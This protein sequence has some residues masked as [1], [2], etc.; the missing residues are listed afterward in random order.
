MSM[1]NSGGTQ[2]VV[3]TGMGAIS[4]AGIGVDSLWDAVIEKRCCVGPITRFD[5]QEYEVHIAAEVRDYDPVEQGLSKKEARRFARFV[6]YAI[7]ASDEAMADSG[8]N[9]ES[10]DLSRFGCFFGSGIGGLEEFQSGCSTLATKGPKRLN[11]LFIPTMISNIAAGTLSIRYGLRGEC[12]ELVTACATGTHNIGHAYRSIKHGYLDAALVGGTEESVTPV[13]LAGFTNLGALS[14]VKDPLGA[15]RPFDL[16]RSGFVTGEGAGALII[17]SLEH[18]Q[19]RGAQIIAEITGFGSTGDAYHMTA[20]EPEGEGLVRSMKQALDEGGFSVEDI[21]HLN[22][23]GTATPIND[24][25]EAAALITFCEGDASR[26]PITSIKGIVGHTLGAAGALEAIVAA[27][28]V[29]REL[30]PP[31]TGFEVAD[32]ECPVQ[33]PTQALYD[34]PQKVV[35]SNSLGFGGHNATLAISP[36]SE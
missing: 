23:H 22:A 3:I 15:S 13:C 6:Q 19:S 9:L 24:K 25:T 17:E 35:L 26:I 32:P 31:T 10:E 28:S 21:G 7:S 5:T 18:A 33:V 27:R 29:E 20:P 11:P 1:K 12:V 4:P 36:F 30:I 16:N 14:K 34:R 8:I 2:R